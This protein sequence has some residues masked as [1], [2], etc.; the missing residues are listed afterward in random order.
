MLIIISLHHLG[1]VYIPTSC[2]LFKKSL[3]RL[4]SLFRFVSFRFVLLHVQQSLFLY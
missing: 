1:E 2:V 4:F 3:Y